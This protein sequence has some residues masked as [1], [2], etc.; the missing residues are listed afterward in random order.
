MHFSIA[1]LFQHARV[2]TSSFDLASLQFGCIFF[3][4]L[5]FFSGCIIKLDTMNKGNALVL[6]NYNSA[7]SEMLQDDYVS[8]CHRVIFYNVYPQIHLVLDCRRLN[9]GDVSIE[10]FSSHRDITFTCKELQ[11]LRLCSAHINS[12]PGRTI[13]L[14]FL[15]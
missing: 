5:Q 12:E 9:N 6:F 14:P 10:I 13:I 8:S 15:L 2:L 11:T 3:L 4:M 7:H 1:K